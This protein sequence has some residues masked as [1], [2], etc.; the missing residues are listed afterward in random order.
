MSTSMVTKK[1]TRKPRRQQLLLIPQATTFFPYLLSNLLSNNIPTSQLIKHDEMNGNTTPRVTNI[2][3][4]DM[5]LNQALFKSAQFL[6][7]IFRDH[8]TSF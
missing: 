1:L 6:D 5:A 2:S 4:P 7:Q 8:N 3:L